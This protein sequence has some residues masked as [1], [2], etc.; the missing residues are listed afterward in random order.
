MNLRNPLHTGNDT[1]HFGLKARADLR[2]VIKS[3]K[4]NIGAPQKVSPNVRQQIK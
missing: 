1:H 3:Q 2:D 4:R